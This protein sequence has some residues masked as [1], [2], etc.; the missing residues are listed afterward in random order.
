MKQTATPLQLTTFLNTGLYFNIIKKKW[1]QD[2]HCTSSFLNIFYIFLGPYLRS[3]NADEESLVE[4]LYPVKT[5]SISI[6][7]E[8]VTE[9]T[10][11]EKYLDMLVEVKKLREKNSILETINKTLELEIRNLED[12]ENELLKDIEQ[13]TSMNRLLQ[14]TLAQIDIP[15]E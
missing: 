3:T 6:W 14:Q 2:S 4:N 12:N 15:I 10:S 13:L 5:D 7:E 1:F 8:T 9:K 11:E